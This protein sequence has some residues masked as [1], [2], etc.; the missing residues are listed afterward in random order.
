[1][2]QGNVSTGTVQT[3][4]LVSRERQS[5]WQGIVEWIEKGKNQTDTQK[6]T[7]HVPCQV[8]VNMKD[9]EPEV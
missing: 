3:Q 9:G 4:Q 5:I 1:M 8:T 2:F 7:K 6:Q